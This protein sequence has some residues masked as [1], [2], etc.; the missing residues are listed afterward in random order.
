MDAILGKTDAEFLPPDVAGPIMALDQ[1][2]M[3]TGKVRSVEERI[4][5]P[6]GMVRDFWVTKVPR[7]D[8]SGEVCGLVVLATDITE[9]KLAGEEIR[10]ARERLALIIKAANL[11]TW[12]W[13]TQTNALLINDIWATMLGHAK[14]EIEPVVSEWSNRVHPDD[15]EEAFTLAKECLEGRTQTYVSE[16]RLRTKEGG[17]R[18]ILDIGQVT[19]RSP[20]GSP[21]VMAGIHMDITERKHAEEELARQQAQLQYILDTSPVGVAFSTKGLIH[22]ANPRFQELFGVGSGEPSP[23]L[24]VNPKDRTRLVERLQAGEV[25]RDFELQM[26]DRD[27]NVRD[28]LVTYLPI[29]HQGEPGILGWLMDI[30]E[31]KR[32]EED[33]RAREKRFRGYFEHSQ[34]GMSMNHPSKG[35]LEVNPKAVEMLGYSLDELRTTDWAVLTHPDDLAADLEQFERMRAGE[36]DHYSMD[37][38]FLRKDGTV[39]FVNLSVACVR[40]RR[41][42]V[43]LTLASYLDITERKEAEEALARE[44]ERLQ[45]I[46]D[47]SPIGV[48][49]TTDGVA[50]FANPRMAELV[51]MDVGQPASRIYV[52]PEDRDH[53]LALLKEHGVVRDLELQMHGPRGEIRDILVTYLR[54]EYEGEPGVL[55]WLVDV[56]PLKEVE[57]NL[58][59]AKEAAEAATRAKSD[60]LANMSHEIRTPMNAVIGMAHLALQTDLTP[61]QR[62]YL[63][64]IDGSAKALLRI[65]NDI[66]DFSKIE[67]GRMDI[68]KVDFNL[69]DVLDNLGALVTVKAEE[70]GLEILFRT[71][72]EVPLTL[73][74]DPLRL[75]KVLLNLAGNSV[76]F[77]ASGEI[78]VHTELMEK[79]G[80]RALLRFSVAD[81]G[82]GMTGEQAAKLFQAFSQA[83]TSTTRKFG[84]TGLGLSISKRL[85][86]MMGGE[87]SVASEPGRGSTFTFTADFGLQKESRAR[88]AGAVG[89]LRG[90]RVLVV[91]D[92]GTSRDILVEALTAMTFDA[93]AVAGGEE[94]LEALDRA[95]DQGRPFKLVLMDW[96]MPGMDGI[97]TSRRVKSHPRGGAVPTIIMVTSYGREEVMRQAEAAGL[98]GFLIKPVN[99]SVLFNTIMDVFGHKVDKEVRPLKPKQ[100]S[101]SLAHIRGA[102]VLLAEDNEINQ[103]V[104]RELLESVGL[105][106]D[107]AGNGQEAV[108]KARI[109]SYDVVLMDIQMPV[110]DGLSAA[111]ELRREARFADLPILAMTAHAMAGDRDKSLAAGMNDHVTKPIDPDALFA[112]LV[113]WIKPGNREP[114]PESPVPAAGVAGPRP[115]DLPGPLPGVDQALGLKR[116]A[117]N[118][119]LYRKLLLDFAR[120][121]PGSVEAIRSALDAARHDEAARLAHTLKGVAGNIGAMDLHLAAQDVDAAM[122]AGDEAGARA[123]L[124]PTAQ[125]LAE[126]L[127][128]LA[129]L[130]AAAAEETAQ[131]PAGDLDRATVAAALRQTA[132]LLAKS[133]PDAEESFARAREA[134]AGAFPA[135]AARVAAALDQFDFNAA[136]AHLEALARSLDL[137][138]DD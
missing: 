67:A 46:L 103:Q 14:E 37:K 79:T 20:D 52:N 44:R 112:A 8:A 88:R 60:F 115:D 138:L 42:D 66:L 82:I 127:A 48:A 84:G 43:E 59:V 129:P 130:A 75:G 119:K 65:I 39:V 99:Q 16:H 105:V 34:V 11:G 123:A 28:M 64:K 35:W 15:L 122:K 96:K 120:D 54:T 86:E 26:F 72:P 78:V 25:V 94:A 2:A 85:V 57:K 126:V 93:E 101:E 80:D 77:T 6:D 51:D 53:V 22:M 95:A 104:A 5:N 90:M 102:R 70:K 50:R 3:Q 121:Y 29:T 125:R 61:K 56:T 108:D 136:Q 87:I 114:A 18:W 116:V 135:E 62:D 117:G 69:E 24:Y 23:N 98:E 113:Q 55:G 49:I 17:Y 74:G 76:K 81:T 63:K 40:D 91:D 68:E 10:R 118:R 36:M 132:A 32:M 133:N 27:H 47:T 12:E 100:D 71:E 7:F 4:P 134:L 58:A 41:G 89:D 110:M 38:R 137:N 107:I 21:L 83:D 106:V 97:E 92:S 30:T 131:A 111:A 31:R 33:I 128:G 109:G 45:S 73:V 9:R 19:E 124:E 13:D 1:E